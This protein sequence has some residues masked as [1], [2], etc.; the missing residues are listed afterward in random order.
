MAHRISYFQALLHTISFLV[1]WPSSVRTSTL[2]SSVSTTPLPTLLPR[3]GSVWI[4]LPSGMTPVSFPT[5]STAVKST[6][7]TADALPAS[8]SPS[9]PM[10]ETIPAATGS[11]STWKVI[12]AVLLPLFAFAVAAAVFF[13]FRHRHH[14]RNQK[15]QAEEIG[16]MMQ[17]LRNNN[18][19]LQGMTKV[20]EDDIQRVKGMELELRTRETNLV[21]RHA[22]WN[23]YNTKSNNY[24]LAPPGPW[25]ANS[26]ATPP[27]P[28]PASGNRSNNPAGAQSLSGSTLQG[29]LPHA[30]LGLEYL[31]RLNSGTASDST[32]SH[33]SCGS[34]GEVQVYKPP[35]TIPEESP[36]C[37]SSPFDSPLPK[38]NVPTHVN[39]ADHE[40]LFGREKDYR[41][42]IHSSIFAAPIGFS[43]L[44]S[45]PTHPDLVPP[46]L[47]VVKRNS[48]RDSS[49]TLGNNLADGVDKKAL[50]RSIS[51][52]PVVKS[53]LN[54]DVASVTPPA[55]GNAQ[56]ASTD[57]Q[58]TRESPSPTRSPH[59]PVG[60]PK[61]SNSVHGNQAV[62]LSTSTSANDPF[63]T[64]SF[65]PQYPR[66]QTILY[67]RDGVANNLLTTFYVL[68]AL[69]I[70]TPPP[71]VVGAAAYHL[72]ERPD[73]GN[74]NRKSYPFPT[75]SSS[76]SI[77]PISIFADPP[78]PT[79]DIPNARKTIIRPLPQKP[80]IRI[81]SPTTLMPP[82]SRSP[83]KRIPPPPPDAKYKSKVHSPQRPRSR[84]PMH[85]DTTLNPFTLDDF[86]QRQQQ[87]QKL[88]PS[89]P[90]SQCLPRVGTGETV[91]STMYS[92]DDDIDAYKENK[93]SCGRAN[94]FNEMS[95]TLRAMEEEENL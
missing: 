34:S 80:S 73:G 57:Q 40:R 13:Y 39:E 18:M 52:P 4:S 68:L 19:N 48:I 11:I 92:Q 15:E 31:H 1:T 30:A 95:A 62:R 50:R 28:T 66:A 23:G 5:S 82:P 58:T 35:S 2:P 26:H 70:L 3:T 56:M 17:D 53:C 43:P 32:A 61:E 6:A 20:L 45:N 72:R 88:V 94:F 65:L 78:S 86:Q 36:G 8:N 46:P 91:I 87:Q 38:Q 54:N 75:I 16:T 10:S 37:A 67:V 79:V 49:N 64:P 33:G 81:I 27:T 71:T 29:T 89:Y 63:S 83:P 44:R 90:S 69:G 42:A 9:P 14:K 74:A 51:N 24:A 21:Q 60:L 7:S 59:T 47:A 12:L 41:P 25:L 84:I 85:V 76:N 77:A 55:E 93:Q 22:D